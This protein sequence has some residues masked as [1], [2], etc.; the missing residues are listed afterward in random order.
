MMR[1]METSKTRRGVLALTGAALAGL[2]AR[3]STADAAQTAEDYLTGNVEAFTGKVEDLERRF[4]EEASATLLPELEATAQI[5]NALVEEARRSLNPAHL[6][7]LLHGVAVVHAMTAERYMLRGDDGK[8]FTLYQTAI[9][10][11]DR[12]DDRYH[13]QPDTKSVVY[14]MTAWAGMYAGRADVVRRACNYAATASS[15]GV[16]VSAGPAVMA[17]FLARTGAAEMGVRMLERSVIPVVLSDNRAA[18]APGVRNFGEAR[19]YQYGA[20]TYLYAGQWDD[21]ITFA[22]QAAQK[23]P[24]FNRVGRARAELTRAEALIHKGEV[25]EGAAV[26]HGTLVYLSDG[27]AEKLVTDKARGVL[28]AAQRRA[29]QLIEVTLLREVLVPPLV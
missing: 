28:D 29:P 20:E 19:M 12:A 16:G 1:H 11:I 9:N 10:C 15:T 24:W 22:T 18:H 8:A 14:S 4:P 5:G 2:V 23:Y 27:F 7:V 13:G 21:A 17:R 26:A 3:P 25:A 6:M